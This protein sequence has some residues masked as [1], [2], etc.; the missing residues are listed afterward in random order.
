MIN[1]SNEKAPVDNP[2]LSMGSLGAEL[3]RDLRATFT[4]DDAGTL[5]VLEQLCAAADRAEAA[6]KTIS[7]DGQMI[8]DRFGAKK[9]HPLL[10]VETAAR[11]QVLEGLR[12]LSLESLEPPAPPPRRRGPMG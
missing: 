9:V 5:A 2:H 12:L 3:W 11:A 1:I 4:L 8:V 6:R 7:E 10:A